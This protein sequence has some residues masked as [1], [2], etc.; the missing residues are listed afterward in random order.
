MSES[1]VKDLIICENLVKIYKMGEVRVQALRGL[2]LRVKEGEFLAVQGPSG[3]GKTTLLQIIGGLATPTSGTVIVAG[4]DMSRGKDGSRTKFRQENIGFVFQRF[5]L[6]TYL[7]AVDNVCLALKIQGKKSP[8]SIERVKELLA[9]VGLEQKFYNR[10]LQM[11][12]GEQQRVAI[13][14]AL[15]SQPAIVL[16]DEPTGNLDS[17]NSE[18]IL[19]LMRSLNEEMGQTIM[20]I[21]HDANAADYATR[22]VRMFDGQVVDDG[23]GEQG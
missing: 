23:L 9:K 17:G 18:K 10:P 5:N 2:N 20:M 22:R 12:Q 13:A 7:N 6:L 16:A 14:R 21:T 19:T 11:S 1:G 15:I 3:C 8:D 4:S